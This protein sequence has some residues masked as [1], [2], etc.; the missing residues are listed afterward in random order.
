MRVGWVTHHLPG[1]R[2]NPSLLPGQFAGGAEML[3]WD[4]VA[5]ASEGVQVE[6]I[7]PDEWERA[8][9]CQRVVI[10][11][12]DFLSERAMRELAELRPVVWV[13]HEQ[14]RSDARAYLFGM[15]DPFVCMSDLHAAAEGGWTG[16]SPEVCNGWIDLSEIVSGEKGD[17]ALWA[18]RN[19]PQKGR[20]AARMWAAA[21][22]VELRELTDVPRRTV[23]DAM[24]DARFFVFLPQRLDACPRTLIEAEA[25]GCKIVTNGRAGRR[26]PGSLVEVMEE[27]RNKFW[28]YVLDR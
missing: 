5:S 14:K 9:D 12:T 18:A 16:T 19:H 22:R 10:T 28:K 24:Q 2:G 27:Q 20:L 21:N 26:Q 15:A 17:H 25:A 8:F 23:L 6:W 13:H 1:D 7:G 3:D 4:M 11:G